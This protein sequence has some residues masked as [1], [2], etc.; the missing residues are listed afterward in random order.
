M[1]SRSHAIEAIPN[2]QRALHTTAIVQHPIMFAP[3]ARALALILVLAIAGSHHVRV[4]AFGPSTIACK[5]CE[6]EMI[7]AGAYN[8][9]LCMTFCS[10]LYGRTDCGTMCPLAASGEYKKACQVAGYC[11]ELDAE[12]GSGVDVDWLSEDQ[13]D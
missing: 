8:N 10:P 1:R 12:T 9:G 5:G 3:T 11:P 13:L 7:E 2:P 6:T 4:A